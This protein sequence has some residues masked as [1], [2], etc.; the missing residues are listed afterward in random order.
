MDVLV[1]RIQQ[2][3]ALMAGGLIAALNIF[4]VTGAWS[5]TGTTLAGVN[6]A[7]AATLTFLVQAVPDLQARRIRLDYVERARDQARALVPTAGTMI[8]SIVGRDALC[9]VL[10]ANARERSAH[11]Q[12]LVGDVGAGK[13]GVLVRLTEILAGQGTIPVPIRLLAD[14]FELDFETLARE[15]FLNEVNADLLLAADGE[16]IWRQLRRE[17]K[18]C[19]LADGIDEALPGEPERDNA[20]R[21]AIRKAH[22]QRLPLVLVSRSYQPFLMAD[23]T[24]VTLEPL[25]Y[26]A[27]LAYAGAGG[28]GEPERR[29]SRIVDRAEVVDAPLYLEIARELQVRGLLETTLPGADSVADTDD[30]DRAGLR[31]ALLGTWCRA[32]ISGYLESEVPLNRPERAAAVEYASAYACAGL[33]L[34]RAEVRFDELQDERVLAEVR[35]RLA[36]ADEQAGRVAGVQFI[37]ARLAAEWAGALRLVEVHRSSVRFLDSQMQAY[38]G[39][40]LL[41]AAL[42]DPAYTRQAMEYPGPGREF[43]IALVLSSRGGGQQA[44]DLV[45]PL[46]R[47]TRGRDDSKT[48]DILA[49]ALELDSAAPQPRHGAIAA[50]VSD[51]LP[52]IRGWD[53]R[54]VD[55]AKIRLVRRLGGAARLIDRRH[56]DDACQA[57]PAYASLF[58]IASSERSDLVRLAAAREVGAG[59]PTAYA[60]LRPHLR[61]A[62]SD[63]H[64]SIVGALLTPMLVGSVGSADDMADAESMTRLAR[65]DLE[66]WV[67]HVSAARSRAVR[68]LPISLEIALAQGFK[69]AAN[70]RPPAPGPGDARK[71][72]AEQAEEMLGSS[73]Y[74][75]S[76]LTLLQALCLLTLPGPDLADARANS[77]DIREVVARWLGLAARG[78]DRPK[79]GPR[80]HPFVA[81][82]GILA[83]RMLQTARPQHYCW[84]DEREVIQQIGSG[85]RGQAAASGRHHLWIPPSAGWSELSGRTQQLLADV[86]LL[87]SLTDRYNQPEACEK[88][89][90]RADASDLP[91]CLTRYRQALEPGGSSAIP[92]MSCVDRCVF[93]L[94]PYP[95]PREQPRSMEL[96]E[97]FCH[98]QRELVGARVS[99]RSASPP[100]LEMTRAQLSRF[101]GQM[102]ERARP[103]TRDWWA[104]R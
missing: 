20:I 85:Y 22:R 80:V 78:G 98:R 33:G 88:L 95:A 35:R 51:Q 64:A 38:L 68:E 56:R 10:V 37:D 42:R 46:L 47:A 93:E 28:T 104:R 29:L 57:T 58:T 55:E 75:Y 99:L 86:V 45:E 23:A 70:R 52:R 39:S 25:S 36:A 91:P 62:G 96:S 53:S 34:G 26:E 13:T 76:Q 27:A 9:D 2:N 54:T 101:W 7:V 83:V 44:V 24:I 15:R 18:I 11:P 41:D 43:L 87:M 31:C 100:W 4:A 84:I 6:A 92:G 21:D 97:A 74:W 60:E 77:P 71:Y 61:A 63:Q 59:G 32:L 17:R 30:I 12:V 66:E 1:Q 19:V 16:A 69:H 5:P 67:R 73:R 8:G 82:A 89:R 94:C 72:L 79:G 40:R 3:A 50:A 49:A 103:R 102:A 65:A 81:E 48:L 14:D 90:Q